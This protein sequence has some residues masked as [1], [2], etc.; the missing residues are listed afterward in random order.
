MAVIVTQ[1]ILDPIQFAL[2]TGLDKTPIS[3]A[4]LTREVLELLNRKTKTV[5]HTI[6]STIDTDVFFTLRTEQTV[7]GVPNIHLLEIELHDAALALTVQ[8]NMIARLTLYDGLNP[9]G[10]PWKQF[11]LHSR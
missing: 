9:N 6:D 7:K 11:S 1:G 4:P 3:A 10:L 2:T 5:L 8:E